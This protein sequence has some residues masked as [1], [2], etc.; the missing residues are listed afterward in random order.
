[1]SGRGRRVRRIA[2]I[3]VVAGAVAASAA[4]GGSDTAAP[5]APSCV[6]RVA[7]RG[8]GTKSVQL[9]TIAREVERL[10][11]LEFKRLPK[12]EY[13]S[14]AEMIRRFRADVDKSPDKEIDIAE[15]A[16]LAVGA[17]KP[18]TD[19]EELARNELADD[20]AGYYEQDTHK[21]VVLKESEKKLSTDERITLAHELEHALADQRVGLPDD[22]DGKDPPPTVRRDDEAPAAASALTEGDAT[23]L[24][25]AYALADV[26][27]EVADLLQK[28]S[29]PGYS[30][31]PYYIEATEDFPY[32][33]GAAFACRLYERSGWRAVD[34]AYKNVPTTTAQ[35]LFPE[36]YIAGD[37]FVDPPHAASPG[38]GWKLLDY[39]TIGA[40]DL[41]FL[42]RA[43]GDRLSRGLSEPRLRAA[44]WA[45]GEVKVW[46]RGKRTAVTL[47][48]IEGRH[49]PEIRLC[50]SMRAWARA[51]G[52]PANAISCSG[53]VVRATLHA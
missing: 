2:A 17:I 46:G 11:R 4:C 40:A 44:A 9:Q 8:G 35:I 38:P 3:A 32:T 52:K 30:G 53:R 25:N 7:Q 21:L 39:S 31:V 16:F 48:L 45:G 26:S 47:S 1:M 12:P 6:E 36:R 33:E 24:T 42:F 22:P 14:Q 5:A 34:R 43:P 51:A 10:R 27:K 23:L 49:I 28:P 18:G 15:R 37:G 41:L 29:P 20:V 50:E 13:V 19:L